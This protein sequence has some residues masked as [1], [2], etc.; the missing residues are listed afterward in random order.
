MIFMWWNDYN[1]D[2]F[3][4]LIFQPLLLYQ[5]SGMFIKLLAEQTY[6]DKHCLEQPPK[7]N[8][9]K[10][11]TATKQ[12]THFLQ[13]HGTFSRCLSQTIKIEPDLWSLSHLVLETILSP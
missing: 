6:S 13:L 11:Q 2:L 1:M 9:N 10:P 4:P 3:L 12:R 7:K 5:V 8:K